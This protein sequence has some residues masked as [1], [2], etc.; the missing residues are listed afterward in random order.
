MYPNGLLL[1]HSLHLA[2]SVCIYSR[3]RIP[4]VTYL[5]GNQ[6]LSPQL[7]EAVVGTIS[8]A[9]GG[10]FA[11]ICAVPSDVVK[12]QM[13]SLVL[14]PFNPVLYIYSYSIISR[15]RSAPTPT[16]PSPHSSYSYSY[17]SFLFVLLFYSQSQI[18]SSKPKGFSEAVR[19]VYRQRG[20][21]GFFV[22]AR[23]NLAKDVPI[24]IVKMGV[25][26]STFLQF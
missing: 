21:D 20:I 24:S 12:K 3:Y 16:S 18:L 23:A 25:Y 1:H 7:H 15:C 17:S 6:P 8:S 9:C 22:G 11:S 5:L 19:S 10:T 13:V 14:L 4:G 26:E 2:S